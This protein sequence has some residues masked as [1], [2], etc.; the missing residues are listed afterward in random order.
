MPPAAPD[1]RSLSLPA[2]PPAPRPTNP[3]LTAL[4]VA[5]QVSAMI[6]YWD[7]SERCLFANDAYRHWFGRE[8]GE[9]IGIT[10][11]ELLGPLYPKNLPYIRGA[12]AGKIQVFERQIPLPG[13]GH[14]DSIATYTPDIV[15]GVVRGFAAHV[16]DVSPLRQR[17]AALA[18]AIREAVQAIEST[19]DSFR[20][21]QLGT[22]RQRLL[23]V[24]D[25]LQDR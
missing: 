3:D 11:R 16:A 12:L 25:R 7:A 24:L 6:A 2:T 21:K 18:L 8:P 15:D 9:M 10:L 14:R 5:N 1:G 23:Q 17:E 22:L 4:R 13:G 19:K 20:S